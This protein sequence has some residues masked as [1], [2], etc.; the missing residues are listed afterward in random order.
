[1]SINRFQNSKLFRFL[2]CL[3]I[4]DLLVFQ[5]LYGQEFQLQETNVY[6]PVKETGG[7][8]TSEDSRLHTPEQDFW[9]EGPLSE[10]TVE[11]SSN[12]ILNEVKDLDPSAAPQ[13]DR[14]HDSLRSNGQESF[15]YALELIG[16]EF[17]SAVILKDMQKEDIQRLLDLDIETAIAVLHGEIVLFSTG[18]EEEIG[19]TAPARNLLEAADFIS[20]TH[21]TRQSREGPSSFDFRHALTSPGEEYVLT[22]NGVYAYN[23]EG[24]L[25]EG[26]S[27]SYLDYLTKLQEALSGN[28]ARDEVQARVLLNEFIRQMDL[29][30]EAPEGMKSSFRRSAPAPKTQNYY[31]SE[32]NLTR[33]LTTTYYEDAKTKTTDDY[34]YSGAILTT[35]DY[36][37]YS[38]TGS[39]IRFLNQSYHPDGKILKV[40]N[41]Y[42]YSPEGVVTGRYYRAYDTNGA[43]TRSL[44]QG[45]DSDGNPKFSDDYNYYSPEGA[46][47]GRNY[48]QYNEAGIKT[49]FLTQTYHPDGKLK[50]S[51]DYYY[52]PEGVV[53]GRYYRAYDTNGAQTRSLTQGYDSDGNPKFSDD[54]N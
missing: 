45:Y 37:S 31:D 27:I 50:V 4:L 3:I 49:R 6:T 8:L 51:N 16:P 13:D 53:T 11:L 33:R 40:T 19:V 34:R 48:Y 36:R 17:A 15:A 46:V 41:D 44:T 14:K 28:A 47:T 10:A 29:Y 23:N 22:R 26:N 1:M 21:I 20:H 18:N 24:L 39:L 32:G 35:R 9:H 38:T 30:N 42:Y 7:I 54:Y 2:A 12:V 5:N 52:S 43:Q 25:N